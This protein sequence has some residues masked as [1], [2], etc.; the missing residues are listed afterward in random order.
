MDCKCAGQPQP[1]LPQWWQMT[2][3][4]YTP[5]M[6]I[7]PCAPE[8]VIHLV[9]YS[10]IRDDVLYIANVELSCWDVQKCVS[11]LRRKSSVITM[12]L[13]KLTPETLIM[14]FQTLSA[15]VKFQYIFHFNTYYI[16]VW[17]FK[18][19]MFNDPIKRVYIAIY[20]SAYILWLI[21]GTLHKSSLKVKI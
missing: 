19:P 18:I 9:R 12:K 6:C 5:V 11:L 7:F 4:N 14:S 1:N 17:K 10:C 8:S 20:T 21:W 13:K 3:H 15:F 16:P 2:G